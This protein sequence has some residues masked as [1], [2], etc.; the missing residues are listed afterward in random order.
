MHKH[1][2]SSYVRHLNVSRPQVKSQLRAYSLYVNDDGSASLH[3]SML[4]RKESEMK[5][6]ALA[7]TKSCENFT[8]K[9]VKILKFFFLS[10]LA[11]S[12]LLT[13]GHLKALIASFVEESFFMDWQCAYCVCISNNMNDSKTCIWSMEV[14]KSGGDL[15]TNTVKSVC[16][17]IV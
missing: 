8:E 14:L 3:F 2:E 5:A 13:N 6:A 10:L 7:T 11:L 12:S 4:L 1:S 17:V 16:V 9:K 15:C